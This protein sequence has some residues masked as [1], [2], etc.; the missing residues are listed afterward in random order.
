MVSIR[1]LEKL[2][3][4]FSI[5]WGASSEFTYY[6]V[7]RRNDIKVRIDEYDDIPYKT[8]LENAA[9]KLGLID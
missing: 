6:Q 4:P 1:K 5:D 7:Y 9:R 3:E 2:L 8:Q